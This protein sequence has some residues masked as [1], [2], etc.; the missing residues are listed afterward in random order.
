MVSLLF[1]CFQL[2]GSNEVKLWNAIFVWAQQRV[3]KILCFNYLCSSIFA[4][5]SNLNNNICLSFTF[6]LSL[7]LGT[8]KACV[9]I[10]SIFCSFELDQILYELRQHSAGLNC[11]MWDY[12]ASLV[13]NFGMYKDSFS[14]IIQYVRKLQYYQM[15]K[16]ETQKMYQNKLLDVEVN[17]FFNQNFRSCFSYYHLSSDPNFLAC[18]ACDVISLNGRGQ[19]QQK[20]KSRDCYVTFK[21]KIANRLI[22]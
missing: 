6:Q 20:C 5:I 8:I 1:C 11:G 13:S 22:V 4:R 16:Y 12:S 17:Y 18:T 19:L 14:L 15:W 2:E 21:P 9:L 3:T 10:E 7:P